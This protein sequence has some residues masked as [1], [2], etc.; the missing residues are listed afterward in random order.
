LYFARIFWLFWWSYL[1]KYR[2]VGSFRAL[3]VVL[4]CGCVEEQEYRLSVSNIMKINSQ[5]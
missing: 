1:I 5:S 4:E 2:L 3:I